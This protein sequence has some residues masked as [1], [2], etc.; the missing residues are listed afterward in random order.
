M[1]E[2]KR[3]VTKNGREEKAMAVGLC[4]PRPGLHS[5]QSAEFIEILL[6]RDLGVW[7]A[8]GVQSWHDSLAVELCS[9]VLLS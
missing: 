8:S 4:A 9:S 3:K 6:C 7:A 1:V 2:T 5:S